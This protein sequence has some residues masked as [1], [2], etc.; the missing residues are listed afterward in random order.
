MIKR[1]ALVWSG[2][3]EHAIASKLLHEGVRVFALPWNPWIEKEWATLVEFEG[4][5]NGLVESIKKLAIDL[6]VV[7]P[8]KY[9]CDGIVNA[10]KDTGINV[11]W[12]EQAAS[13]LEWDKENAKIFMQQ[14]GI[15]TASSQTFFNQKDVE[16][17]LPTIKYP[18]V[19]KQSGLASGKWVKICYNSEEAS[20]FSSAYFS[21]VWIPHKKL[22]VEDFLV[23]REVS[24][25]A[26]I[27]TISETFKI[28]TTA[29]D[30]KAESDGWQWDMTWWMGTFSPAIVSEKLQ[31]NIEMMFQNVLHWLKDSW[32]HYTWPLFAGL[33][34]DENDAFN[35][36]EFNARFWDPETQ[37]MLPRMQTSLY[38]LMLKNAEGNLHRVDE[39]RFSSQKAVTV[40]LADPWYPRIWTHTGSIIPWLH[41]LP[42]D[43]KV[44]HMGTK[45][46]EDGS[47]LV[48][49]WRVLALTSVAETYKEAQKKVYSALQIIRFWDDIPKYRTDIWSFAVENEKALIIN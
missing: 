34:V 44:F 30:H 40:V 49:G 45:K 7:W 31:K 47:I 41:E 14:Y 29:T 27:D 48:N 1:I 32:L 6:V 9:L 39:I 17:F 42:Q 5:L 20:L 35:I 10:L 21:D 28:F 16:N 22:I 24:A 26:F 18:K 36:L 38:D 23:W 37:S 43:V 2:W 4:G 11:L 33:M 19:L 25:F 46:W 15:P 12:P 8:E 3:R 13:F